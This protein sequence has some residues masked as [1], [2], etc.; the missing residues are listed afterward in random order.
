M[1]LAQKIR[2]C[3]NATCIA[4]LKTFL[5]FFN[6]IIFVMGLSL[7]TLSV[8]GFKNFQELFSVSA[9]ST[10]WFVILTTGLLMFTLSVMSFWCIPRGISWL[11]YVYGTIVFI[12][13]VAVIVLSSVFMVRRD[14]LET[15]IGL[16][17]ST[18]MDSYTSNPE[19]VDLVQREIKCCGLLNYKDWFM[20]EWANHTQSVPLSCCI[21]TH[22]CVTTGSN[23]LNFTGIWDKGCYV[24]M[25][26]I[27]EDKYTLI[28]GL[29]FASATLVFLGSVLSFWLASNINH[30]RYEQFQ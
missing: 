21:D 15:R 20:T 8:Y 24:K 6:I 13:F 25:T 30:N 2:S 19:P 22:N 4:M 5:I 18:Q 12:L 3:G 1:P 27:I 14:Y 9:S 28:G 17:F 11:L 29:G 7:V 26:S 23:A 10:I 16:E